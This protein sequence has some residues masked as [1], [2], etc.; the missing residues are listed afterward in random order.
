MNAL[1]AIQLL[2]RL[3]PMP[4]R[5]DLDVEAGVIFGVDGDPLIV[6]DSFQDRELTD[7]EVH[8]I[9]SVVAVAV[10]E[11]TERNRL[12]I[13]E[14]TDD[15][16]IKHLCADYMRQERPTAISCIR[17]AICFA[18]DYG[19]VVPSDYM[20]RKQLRAFCAASPVLIA[21]ARGVS[22]SRAEFSLKRALAEVR[23]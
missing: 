6:V 14:N 4:L 5:T 18:K 10:N 23:S 13:A 1:K 12:I 8:I 21:S 22:S 16:V 11:W 2:D 19:Y 3:S 20:L 9:A 7:E 15:P 17:R